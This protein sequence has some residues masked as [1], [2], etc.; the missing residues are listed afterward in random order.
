[1]RY[2]L[3]ADLS[4]C[5]QEHCLTWQAEREALVSKTVLNIERNQTI[6]VVIMHMYY[7]YYRGADKKTNYE[8][9]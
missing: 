8:E 2:A 5:P 6:S 3:P 4:F 9:N 1:M 7:C